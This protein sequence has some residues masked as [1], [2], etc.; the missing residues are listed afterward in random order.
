M[1]MNQEEAR[2]R[3][4]EFVWIMEIHREPTRTMSGLKYG[5]HAYR[6]FI[7]ECIIA[8]LT[9]LALDKV[10]LPSFV[11]VQVSATRL[12]SKPVREL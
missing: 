4:Q 6:L 10:N 9:H 8:G 2:S 5:Q 12:L 3:S 7:T 1:H 11:V